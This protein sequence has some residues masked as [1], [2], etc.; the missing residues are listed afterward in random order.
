MQ[1]LVT[2]ALHPKITAAL[3]GL[4]AG[5]DM[6]GPE[7]GR[8][9]GW[10]QWYG[11]TDGKDAAKVRRTSDYFDVVHFA[12][13]IKCPVLIGAGLAD[14]VCPLEGI[15]AAYN[16]IRAPKELIIL[17]SASHNN[18]NGSHEPY[19]DRCY[20]KWLP[21]LQQGKRPLVKQ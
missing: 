4:P 18:E 3:A 13:Q 12:A 10:P 14:D 2:A 17:P 21:A 7:I 11:R 8:L 9:G 1:A 6:R 19:N 15:V 5:C 20:K 16:Q